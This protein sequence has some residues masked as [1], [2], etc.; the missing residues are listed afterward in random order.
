ME[1]AVGGCPVYGYTGTRPFL[2]GQRT[3]LF[4]HGAANDHGVFAQQSRYFAW[5]G[6]NALSLDLPGHGRSHGSAHE[7]VE[8]LA[9]WL[10]HVLD[11]LGV[12]NADLVGHSL[13]A[14]AAL[15]CA[16]RYPQRIRRLAL[17]GPAAPMTVSEE[18]LD[19]AKRDD[20]VAYEL[21]NSW[22]FAG[23]SQLGGNRVPGMWML[24]NAMRLMERTPPGTLYVDLAACN[25]YANGTAAATA[26][27]CPTLVVIGARD[28]MAPPRNAQPLVKAL[29]DVRTVTLPDTGHAMMAERPE[30]VLDALRAFLL[31]ADP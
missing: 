14:L 1:F 30:D 26:V 28:I 13:G 11:A 21:I 16:A 19:A 2:P 7:S 27:S 17:L 18:L 12:K 29:R 20:H 8:A 25:A 24:G 22:S 4:V 15:E 23:G 31:T 6:V 3:V 10:V 5:H 9:E